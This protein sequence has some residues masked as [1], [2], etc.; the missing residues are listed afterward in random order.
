MCAALPTLFRSMRPAHAQPLHK[1][2]PAGRTLW[3]LGDSQTWHSYYAAECFLRD[4]AVDWFRRPPSADPAIVAALSP[5]TWPIPV[6]PM[7]I[8]L[9]DETRVCNVRG[10][11]FTLWSNRD[12]QVHAADCLRL[13]ISPGLITACQ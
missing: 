10:R 4:H 13:H 1:S 8:H 6:A 5:V 7:C 11:P 9:R 12:A 2:L 3:F